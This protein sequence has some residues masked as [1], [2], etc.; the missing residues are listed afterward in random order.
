MVPYGIGLRLSAQ[1]SR[2]LSEPATLLEMVEAGLDAMASSVGLGFHRMDGDTGRLKYNEYR[3]YVHNRA[4]KFDVVLDSF[5]VT[6][7]K[8]ING[9][10]TATSV[11]GAVGYDMSKQFRLEADAVY[12]RNPYYDK[13]IRGFFKLIYKFN[14]MPQAK[15]GV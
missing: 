6:Y 11:S 15:K 2:E 1:A 10:K 12:S 9:R 5:F 14:I 13:D 3:A 4:G 8:E 7:D